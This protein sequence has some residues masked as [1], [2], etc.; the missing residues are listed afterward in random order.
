MKNLWGILILIVLGAAAAY[1]YFNK[2][3]PT[4]IGETYSDFAVEDTSSIQKIFIS[5]TFG[6]QV[7]LSRGEKGYWVINN[8]QRA[9]QDAIDLMLVT[10]KHIEIQSPVSQAQFAAVVKRLA[11]ASTK[12]EIYQGDSK[13]SK[14]YYFGEPTLSRLGTYTLLA[15]DGKKSDK[16]FI[17]HVPTERGF[18]TSRFFTD[19]S[20]WRDRA[21]FRY[22]PDEI[23]SIEVRTTADTVTSFRIESLGNSL[24]ELTDLDQ[25]KKI[26]VPFRIAKPYF[27]LFKDYHYEYID[28]KTPKEKIDSVIAS[29]PRHRIKIK[30]NSW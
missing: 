27:D 29:P 26:A 1:I 6:E 10:F 13:P 14:V 22:N 17:T 24:F 23:R 11:T 9:R 2:A 12:V 7:L 28:K 16:P 30:I 20:L 15:K 4:T 18:L 19:P 8:D 25:N 21:M 3:K 5:N